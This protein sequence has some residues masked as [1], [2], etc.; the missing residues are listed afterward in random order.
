MLRRASRRGRR[1]YSGNRACKRVACVPKR[2]SCHIAFVMDPIETFSVKKDSTLAMIRA[3]QRRGWRISVLGVGDLAL[4]HGG[5][6]GWMRDLAL[7]DDAVADIDAIDGDG[8]YRA[9][10]KLRLLLADVDI[11]MMRKDPPFDMGYVYA[12]Y[13]LERAVDQ[14]AVVVNAPRALRDCNEKFYA[15]AFAQCAPPLIVAS[16]KDLLL[17]FH[18]EHGDVVYKKLD[19]MGG[20]S[21]FRVRQDDPNLRVVIETLTDNEKQPVMA[22]KFIPE[23][24]AGDKRIL[25]IDGKPVPYAL[26]RIPM[27]GETRGNLAAGGKAVGQPLTER[28][29]FI[30]ES[31]GGELEARGLRFVGIDVI[32]DYLTEINVTCPTCIRELDRSFGLDIAGDLLDAIAGSLG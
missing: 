5:V 22:Q 12:T 32:G 9:G 29:R 19:G 1:V 4:Q 17:D 3:A 10:P 16:R 27:Q 11:V 23:I 28:D 30:A 8:Y 13:L 31:V 26:A 21:I 6:V 24:S 7:A 14:G 2:A 18:A 20:M 15:T 25:L